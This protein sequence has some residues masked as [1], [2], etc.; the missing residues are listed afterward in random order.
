METCW[1]RAASYTTEPL[2]RVHRI[3]GKLSF[4]GPIPL[5]RTFT[6]N[7]MAYGAGAADRTVRHATIRAIVRGAETQDRRF[8]IYVL[9][10]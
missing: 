2:W 7:L 8:S 10:S 6:T 4:R 5:L 1:T 3:F 9:G